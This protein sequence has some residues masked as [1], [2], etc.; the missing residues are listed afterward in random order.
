MTQP[1]AQPKIFH[2][3]HV[4]NLPSIVSDGNL[5]SDRRMQSVGGPNA[6]VGMSAIKSR[7]LTSLAVNCCPGTYVG[8]FVP[9]Y[10]C[11]RSVMLYLLHKGNHPGLNYAGG[12][13]PIVHLQADLT[14][15]VQWATS[16]RRPWAF[17]AATAA[18]FYT[19]GS[20]Y[21]S[22]TELS[23]V[24]WNAVASTDFRQPSVKEGK[25]AEFLLHDS[26]P[27]TLVERIGVHSVAIRAQVLNVLA[28]GSHRPHVA[29]EP[30]WYF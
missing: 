11:P 3:T 2:I 30:S 20:F 8:D 24:D 15:V 5:W 17:C 18:A 26:F 1:P 22:L 21:S 14:S 12:Q 19:Q 4:N 13:G 23:R 16:S 28:T 7:R 27:W 10:F 9:F 25:Q 29:I 6:A